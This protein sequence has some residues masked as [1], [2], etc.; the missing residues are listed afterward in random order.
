MSSPT[1]PSPTVP[2]ELPQETKTEWDHARVE[3]EK[4]RGLR[5]ANSFG[6]LDDLQTEFC[7]ADGGVLGVYRDL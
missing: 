3:A 7:G 6:Q 5:Y 1:T 4:A 2:Q